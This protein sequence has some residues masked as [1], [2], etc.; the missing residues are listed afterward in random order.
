MGVEIIQ[1]AVGRLMRGL[2]KPLGFPGAVDTSENPRGRHPTLSRRTLLGMVPLAP[3]AIAALGIVASGAETAVA[4]PLSVAAN[5]AVGSDAVR[6]ATGRAVTVQK[7]PDSRFRPQ[8]GALEP[9]VAI[10]DLGKIG[11]VRQDDDLPLVPEDTAAGAGDPPIVPGVECPS[12]VTAV[13]PNVQSKPAT[14]E[15]GISAPPREGT[16]QQEEDVR[17]VTPANDDSLKSAIEARIST[18]SPAIFDGDYNGRGTEAEKLGRV[19][20]AK[21]VAQGL[22]IGGEAENAASFFIGHTKTPVNGLATSDVRLN[23][24]LSMGAPD[25]GTLEN[26]QDW[27]LSLQEPLK[28]YFN[29]IPEHVSQRPRTIARLVC[30]GVL[31]GSSGNFADMRVDDA[32]LSF[33]SIRAKKTIELM[34]D[35]VTQRIQGINP[36]LPDTEKDKKVQEI[37]RDLKEGRMNTLQRGDSSIDITVEAQRQAL[38]G[39]LGAVDSGKKLYVDSE[40][41]VM[42]DAVRGKI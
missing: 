36:N 9:R 10:G 26:T 39:V 38:K 1:E 28:I 19:F 24:A 5:P 27:N 8:T 14:S 34:R 4:A 11:S 35:A 18:V 3:A 32:W 42:L 7:G 41:Q 21:M 12:E 17:E 6:E 31:N 37:D 25:L 22:E 15:E 30:F 13:D 23:P 33:Y 29:I 20:F 16:L 2:R 40:L